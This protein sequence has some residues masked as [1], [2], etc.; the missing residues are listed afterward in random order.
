VKPPQQSVSNEQPPPRVVT[1]H[2]AICCFFPKSEFDFFAF[3]LEK[4]LSSFSAM[5][6]ERADADGIA[7]TTIDGSDVCNGS[8]SATAG[9]RSENTNAIIKKVLWRILIS[10]VA[11]DVD[12]SRREL[13][14]GDGASSS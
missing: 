3:E 7:A 5:P 9:V 8:P 1:L 11:S 12:L 13:I 4:G 2:A 6:S 10:F 14:A